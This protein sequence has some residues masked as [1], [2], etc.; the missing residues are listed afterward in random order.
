MVV[1]LTIVALVSV[2]LYR[3]RQIIGPLLLSAIIAYILSPLAHRVQNGS[4]LSW[5]TSVTLVYLLLVIVLITLIAWAGINV[6]QQVTNLIITLQGFVEDL[7]DFVRDFSS[8]VYMIGPFQLDLSQLEL[9]SLANQLLNTLQPLLGEMTGLVST[10]ATQTVSTLGWLFFVLLVGYFLLA[11]A[12]GISR[13]VVPLN[14]PGY[15]DDIRQLNLRLKVI[16]ATF[17][18]GQLIIVTL[19]V[20]VYWLLMLILGVRYALAIALMAG[21]ARFLPYIGPAITWTVLALLSFFQ[22]SN[23]FGLEPLK[24]AMLVLAVAVV[25]D[26]IF[27]NMVSPRFF[28]KTLGVHP[29]AVLISAI[30]A[31]NLLGIVGLLLAAPVLASLQLFVGYVMRKMFDMEPWP[32]EQPPV[33]LTMPWVSWIRSVRQRWQSRYKA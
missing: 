31:A 26:W 7:P 2:L 32:E 5:R 22:G 27:D 13:P 24:F 18:R 25:T 1:G 17:L 15:I 8:K 21:A 20:F 3:F 28:G 14:I 9:E 23:H 19:T 4:Q 10:I 6:V 11:D 29:A 12:G 33:D 30:I 16:W